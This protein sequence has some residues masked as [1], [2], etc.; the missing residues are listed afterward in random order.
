MERKSIY[1]LCIWKNI[2][3]PPKQTK[4]VERSMSLSQHFV[5]T[6]NLCKFYMFHLRQIPLRGGIEIWRECEFKTHTLRGCGI[7][8]VGVPKLSWRCGRSRVEQKT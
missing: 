3:Q 7:G 4:L 6:W 5:F 2:Y 8:L 1:I